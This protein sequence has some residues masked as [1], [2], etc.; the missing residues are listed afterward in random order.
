MSIGGA[1]WVLGAFVLAL[2]VLI[3]VHE[4]GHYL[5]AR[6]CNVKI[7]R[8][9]VGFGRPLWLRRWG[10]DDT[11]W[12]VSVFPLGGYVKML[13]EREGDVAPEEVH[14]AFNRQSVGRRSL[15]VVAG[16]VA[17]LLLAV[18]LYWFLFMQGVEEPRPI[19][20]SPQAGTVAAMTKVGAG[21]TAR[22]V[23]GV[24]VTTWSE[25]RWE[26][27]QRAL[28]HEVITLE[29]IN[30]QG[31][32]AIH[33]LDTAHL[34]S[35]ALEGDIMQPLGLR[36][37]RPDLPAV[38]GNIQAGSPAEKVGLLPGDRVTMLNG[39]SVSG[40]HML[41]QGIREAGA[42]EIVLVV[43][44]G[45]QQL[46]FTVTPELMAPAEG[47]TKPRAR[48]GIAVRDD[49]ELRHNT[50][51]TVS[52]GPV[53]SLR[54]A[55][56]QTRETSVLSL[57]M[58]GRML[59]GELSL[60]NISGPV[61]IADYAGQSARMGAEHYLRFL[62]LISISLGVLNLLPIPVLDGGHLMYYLAE[63][64][65]GGPLSERVMEIG[66]QV[67]LTLLALLMALAFYNDINRLISG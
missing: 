54:R 14:R 25:F 35:D 17:N 16:P 40:W 39:Q 30:A 23:S 63:V 26:V 46:E 19:L 9:S 7:L 61:T 22:K 52:Y 49:S 4:F 44:R 50:W 58:M 64:I 37:M 62:A 31:A 57:R 55:F 29:T 2:G 43:E 66:Q 8:F 3:T 33:R 65:K 12:A 6:W 53:E 51:I 47:E 13:D 32:I 67:G 59:M 5:V 21:E 34:S 20:A 15:I 38:L 45:G 27:L 42:R 24:S 1:V 41:A 28:N 10:K 18:F 56:T 48:I 36:L 11:E 60:K